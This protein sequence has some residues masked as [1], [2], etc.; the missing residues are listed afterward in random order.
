MCP[1]FMVTREEEATTRGRARMLFEMFRGEVIGKYGW[2]DEDVKRALDLCLA[3]KG[4]KGDCPLHV[5]MATYK[6]EFLAHYYE[7]RLRP[8]AAYAMGL[9]QWWARMG[10]LA[11][12][13]ANFLS[14]AWPFANW[15]KWL[16]G[17]APERAIPLFAGE[18]FK[19]WFGRRP[20]RN[21][22]K[23]RVI[24]WADTFNNHFLPETAKAAVEVLEAAGFQVS[25]PRQHLCCGRPLYDWGML[26]LAKRNLCKILSVLRE[27]I[28]AGVPVVSLEPSCAAVFRDELVNLFPNNED[29]L[30]LSQQTYMLSEFLMKKAPDF[31]MPKLEGKA[32]LHGHCHHKAIVKMTDEI[33]VLQKLGMTVDAPETGCCGM[34]G[35]FGFEENH[36]D[37]SMKCGERV[38]FPAIRE[39][40]KETV[41][42]AD[43]FSCREQIEGGTDRRALH[44]AQVLQMALHEGREERVG[45]PPEAGYPGV[46]D[47]PRSP[48]RAFWVVT[49]MGAAMLAWRLVY[50]K[51]RWR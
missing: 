26:A 22:D 42:V 10:S 40:T 7:G 32:L 4:C 5:D 14:H 16:G 15:F 38:L 2:H 48:S 6:A 25:V 37:V 19:A 45:L 21:A 9:I 31:K 49:L 33:A 35:S 47:A 20:A 11:P 41:I 24:L 12:G 30:R 36:Y 23:P 28:R 29:A 43:G 46:V 18:T 50:R 34:A 3:C 51:P 17:I 1:S 8:R 13:L 39:A 44:L 27:D